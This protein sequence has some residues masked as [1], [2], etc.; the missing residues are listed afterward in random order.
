MPNNK[1]VVAGNWESFSHFMA[2][3]YMSDRAAT[4]YLWQVGSNAGG[5]IDEANNIAIGKL[6]AD[7]IKAGNMESADIGGGLRG[8]TIFAYLVRVV[9]ENGER[10]ELAG[11]VE[12]VIA[13]LKDYPVVDDEILSELESDATYE[14]LKDQVR[15][16]CN[17]YDIEETD[18]L[19]DRVDALMDH[20]ED[21]S[22][23]GEGGWPYE[24]SIERVLTELGLLVDVDEAE[25][26]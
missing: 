11:R 20:D 8:V 26:V 14:N 18:D 19:V 2:G 6:F 13:D 16:V 10:T 4:H 21:Y 24:E 25:T 7:D 12:K 22:D 17:K 1:E 9:G 3:S 5:L 15:S 23:D